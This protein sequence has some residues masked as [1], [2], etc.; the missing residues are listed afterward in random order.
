M[1]TD[2]HSGDISRQ[3][4][5]PTT[6]DVLPE[7]QESDA[8]PDIKAIYAEIRRLKGAPMVALIWRHLATLPDVLPGA[9]SSIAPILRSGLLQ[10]TAWTIAGS[11]RLQPL[12][13]LSVAELERMGVDAAA[14]ASIAT[15]LDAYNRANPV[16]MLCVYV[17]LAR[18]IRPDGQALAPDVIRW[19]PPAPVG[20][21]PRMFA[22][23]EMPPSI[24]QQLEG[25]TNSAEARGGP[26]TGGGGRA[27]PSLYR[28]L[29]PWP[30]YIDWLSNVMLPQAGDGG[31]RQAIASIR[32]SMTREAEALV[33]HVP[34]ALAL[35]AQPMAKT[36]LTRFSSLIPEMI[37]VGKLL[38]GAMPRTN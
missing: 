20:P 23:A 3:G 4:I 19:D 11:V 22:P 10:E 33:V 2:Q 16:N 32:A 35:Q 8:P 15:V 38:A 12:P 17:L 6:L 9:W 29:V 30:A 1:P 18:L 26:D 28:H 5:A 7:L 25:L 34:P 21:L 36:A 27:I 31:I 37:V 14:R 24:R 13:H